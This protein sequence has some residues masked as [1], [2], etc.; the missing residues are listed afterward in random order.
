MT[1]FIQGDFFSMPLFN[2]QPLQVLEILQSCL[3]CILKHSQADTLTA[4]TLQLFIFIIRCFL[5]ILKRWDVIYCN[6]EIID[7]NNK[8]HLQ[9]HCR[10]N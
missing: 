8:P 5:S 10:N 2:L 4:E 7:D 9:K 6:K 1:L 3:S